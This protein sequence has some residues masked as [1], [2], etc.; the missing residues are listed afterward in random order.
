MQGTSPLTGSIVVEDVIYEHVSGDASLIFPSGDLIFRRLIFQRTESLVQS[1][2]LLTRE[3]LREN[4][5]GQMDRKK[6]PSSSKSK[7]KEKKR[8]NKGNK[9]RSLIFR[10]RLSCLN[11]I[12][13]FFAFSLFSCH[14]P[15]VLYFEP[16][17]NEKNKV[18]LIFSIIFLEQMQST[19]CIGI[20]FVLGSI[21]FQNF[22]SI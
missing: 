19:L 12:L 8:V 11:V 9:L 7:N 4:V 3:T 15:I 6:S 13:F 22:L 2:A 14:F 17:L 1:E 21:F 20:N 10:I 16:Y 5:S 18:L